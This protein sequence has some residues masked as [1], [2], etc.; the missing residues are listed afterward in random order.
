[1]TNDSQSESGGVVS[2]TA[3]LGCPWC[4]QE[5]QVTKHHKHDVWSLVHRCSVFT[6]LHIDWTELESLRQRWNTRK[7]PNNAINQLDAIKPL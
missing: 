3:W 5:P 2:S 6:T 1:M 7:Q 4:G